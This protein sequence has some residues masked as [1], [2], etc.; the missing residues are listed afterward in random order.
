M[1]LDYAHDDGRL[2]AKNPAT[3]TK[4]PPMRRTTHTYLTAREVADLA[5]VC[6][7]QGDVVLILAYPG[8]RLVR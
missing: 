5:D 2:I 1:T 6:G 4:F 7:A 8:L 3:R